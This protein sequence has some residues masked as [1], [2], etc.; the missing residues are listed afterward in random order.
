[1]KYIKSFNESIDPVSSV[2]FNIFERDHKWCKFTDEEIDI[3][4]ANIET[5][6]LL[7]EKTEVD[8][9]NGKY[10]M[11]YTNKI[12]VSYYITKFEDEWYTVRSRDY[13]GKEISYICDQFDE[14]ILLLKKLK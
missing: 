11:H 5:S 14:L 2:Q 3:I 13:T 12:F 1:M 7:G 6:I 4:K 9:N 8:F 10:S